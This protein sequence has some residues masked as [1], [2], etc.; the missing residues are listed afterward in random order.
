MAFFVDETSSEQSNRQTVYRQLF[1]FLDDP[2][3]PDVQVLLMRFD[4]ALHI[5]TPWTSDT[6]RLRGGVATMSR[7]KAAPLLGVPGQLSNNPEQGASNLQ[8]DAVD[9]AVHVRSSLASIFDA[10]RVFP[11]SPGR[12]ALFVVTDG[13]PFLTPFEIARDLI[14]TTPSGDPSLPRTSNEVDYDR[15]LLFD[16]LAWSR[17]RSNSMLTEIARLAVLREIEVHPVRSAAHDLDGRVRADRGFHERATLGA[18]RPTNPRSLRAAETPPTTDIAAGQSMEETAEAT[19]GEAIL[20]RRSLEDGVRREV[21]LADAAYA[22]SFRDPFAGDHRFHRIESSTD[23]AG[24][25]LRY[26]RGYRVL[27]TREALLQGVTNRLY[28]RGDENPLNARVQLDSFGMEQG[29]AIAQITVA[30]PAPPEAGGQVSA[31]GSA[32]VLGVCSVRNGRISDPIDLGGIPEKTR[33]GEA[34][35]LV[36]SG[37]VRVKPGTHRWSFAIHDDQTGITSYLSFDRALP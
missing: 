1:K 14:A 26:R 13:A 9:A 25:Q 34:L 16:S 37:R 22:V 3:P 10:L 20:S 21:A 29:S 24:V 2:L 35:W 17:S 28:L 18:G 5:E 23:Q 27:D 6:A 33:I 11:E 36:R 31:G 7:R 32:R 30:Y 19:G 12:R 8:L 4:G 15:D